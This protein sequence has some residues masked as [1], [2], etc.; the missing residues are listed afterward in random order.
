MHTRDK[1]EPAA[2][3]TILPSTPSQ[4]QQARRGAAIGTGVSDAVL[5]VDDEMRVVWGNDAAATSFVGGPEGLEGRFC[6]EVIHGTRKPCDPAKELCPVATMRVS[7]QPESC[8]KVLEEPDGSR[9][10]CTITAQPVLGPQGEI[11]E[12]VLTRRVDRAPDEVWRIV[13]QQSDD[14]SILHSLAEMANRGCSQGDLLDVLGER[15]RAAF[16]GASAHIYRLDER[17]ERLDLLNVGLPARL[18]TALERLLGAPLP[19][20]SVPLERA[21]LLMAALHAQ[22]AVVMD[23]PDTIGAL[24]REHMDS[25][26]RKRLLGPIA[27]L[28]GIDSVV[29]LPMVNERQV[30]GLLSSSRANA[31]SATELRRLEHIA[32]QVAGLMVRRQ[33][34]EDHRRMVR[35]QALLLQAVT[36]AILGV[37]SEAEVV[38]ANAAASSLLGRSEAA[39]LGRSVRSFCGHGAEGD[40][41]CSGPCPIGRALTSRA[42]QY[43]RDCVVLDASGQRVPVRM[44]AVPLDESE[45]SLVLTMSDVTEQRRA[46]EQQRRTNERLRRSFSGT[47]AA[48]SR[49][50]A[51]RDPYT[52]GHEQRVAQLARAI[53]QRLDLDEEVVDNVRLAATIHDIGK[54]AIPV[55]ILTKPGRLTAR[56]MELIRTHPTTGWEILRSSDFPST[57]ATVVRQHHERLDGS[58]YPDGLYGDAI[59]LE[60][61]IIAVADVVEAMASHRPYRAALGLE[62]ALFE[63]Q[64]HRHTRYDPAVVS[65]CVRAFRS[66]GFAFT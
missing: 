60:A 30:I 63:I 57:I 14:L 65:A 40:D 38:F 56:E 13:Q 27:R 50:A 1:G 11:I 3:P 12:A 46:L 33:A 34:Q 52:A 28:L 59:S 8:N 48:M 32:E 25:P 2:R 6:W 42:A 21:P 41:A 36:D 51:M 45:L 15:V 47:V 44:S 26:S 58:G 29:L 31:Y 43:D 23:D 22:G 64:A 49:L 37:N 10:P 35:R 7:G 4:A 66:D 17:K 24:I 19:E 54:H 5:I 9:T 20:V 61:R 16:E 62:D 53:A 18:R 39:L 55:E